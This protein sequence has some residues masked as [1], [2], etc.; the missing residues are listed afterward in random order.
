MKKALSLLICL[1][2]FMVVFTA[3]SGGGSKTNTTN[4]SGTGGGNTQINDTQ[5]GAQTSITTRNIANEVIGSFGLTNLVGSGTAEAINLSTLSRLTRKIKP[6]IKK[7][8]ISKTAEIIDCADGGSKTSDDTGKVTYDHCRESGIETDGTV[9]ATCSDEEC[10]TLSVTFGENGEPY[11]ETSYSDTFYIN[12]TTEFKALCI[13]SQSIADYVDENTFKETITGNGY[14]KNEYFVDNSLTK[15]H[16]DM[17]NF[18]YTGDYSEDITTK[19]FN[20]T[21][22]SLTE[23][24]YENGELVYS[25]K[26]SFRNYNLMNIAEHI[27]GYEYLSI[28]G[29]FGLDLTPEDNACFEG[30]FNIAT[31]KVMQT[32]VVSQ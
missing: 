13:L 17:N 12:K 24:L 25:K 8:C 20:I 7:S 5:Q 32:S 31:L 28:N 1:L 27:N 4:N 26:T 16:I 22:S 3:C 9:I 29:T 19:T 14:I 30:T 18:I 15:E 11:V 21:D 6:L 2:S 10:N 23:S